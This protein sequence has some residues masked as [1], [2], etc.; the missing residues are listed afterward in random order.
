MAFLSFL[1]DS[2]AETHGVR[3]KRDTLEYTWGAIVSSIFWGATISAVMIK[4]TANYFGRRNG[5]IL[6][7]IIQDI[8]LALEVVSYFVNSYIIYAVAR[9][10]LGS[11]ISVSIGIAPLFIIECRYVSPPTTHSPVRCPSNSIREVQRLLL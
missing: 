6:T 8:A 2:Y 3:L 9:I 1:D 7:F 11:A 10:V 4:G 5:I